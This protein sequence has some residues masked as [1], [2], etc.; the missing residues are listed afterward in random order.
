MEETAG[1]QPFR[2][3]R[4]CNYKTTQK[5]NL[6]QHVK[7]VHKGIKYNCGECHFKAKWKNILQQHLQSVHE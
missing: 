3:V 1:Q 5:G 4:Y 2:G 7:Y 6:L